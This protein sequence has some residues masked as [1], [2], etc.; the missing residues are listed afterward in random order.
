ML[1]ICS[2]AQASAQGRPADLRRRRILH[3]HIAVYGHAARSWLCRGRRR[4]RRLAGGSGRAPVRLRASAGVLLVLRHSLL[5]L[6]PAPGSALPAG[7]A[8]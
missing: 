2:S 8:T 4:R 3:L 6:R 5:R 7:A 1:L